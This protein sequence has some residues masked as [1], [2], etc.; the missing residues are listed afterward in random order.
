MWEN[1][2]LKQRFIYVWAQLKQTVVDKAIDQW[3]TRLRAGI[4][5][6]WQ[7]FEHLPNWLVVFGENCGLMKY[8]AHFAANVTFSFVDMYSAHIPLFPG[9]AYNI[10][11]I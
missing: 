8:A 6:K 5:A 2:D 11:S 3:Q 1:N 4:R 7:H 9:D 10:K